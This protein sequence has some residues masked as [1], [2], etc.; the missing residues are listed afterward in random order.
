MR[1]RAYDNATFAVEDG[2]MV[3]QV[4][5]ATGA[6]YRHACPLAD[7]ETIA[8][9]LDEDTAGGTT[10]ERLHERTGIAWTRI[11]VALRFLDERSIVNHAG[12]RGRL[13]VPATGSVYLDALTEYHTLREGAPGSIGMGGD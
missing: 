3:M 5:P 10:R 13:Y 8:H 2:R 4:T 7:L 11:N 6:P 9:E 12:K 1:P